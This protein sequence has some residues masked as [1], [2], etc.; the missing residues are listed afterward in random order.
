MSEL[1]LHPTLEAYV[2]DLDMFT[3][4]RHP[5][6]FSVPFFGSDFEIER[7]N[8]QFEW[9]T[10]ESIKAKNVGDFS[11]YVFLHERPYRLD[12]FLQVY[13]QMS[14]KDFWRLF[15]DIWSDSENIY[16]LKAIWIHLIRLK[17]KPNFDLVIT[18][19]D[20]PT[21]DALPDTFTVYRGTDDSED[22]DTDSLSWTIDKEQAQWFANRWSKDEPVVLEREISKSDVLSYYNGRSEKEIIIYPK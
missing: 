3:A 2:E 8:K 10:K 7:C 9:K 20:R 15:M 14:E 18:D 1:S 21:F 5:L 19:E 12:A 17:E 16:A 6:V 22:D 11:K 13:K 4:I